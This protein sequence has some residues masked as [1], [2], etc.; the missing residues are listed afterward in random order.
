MD[1]IEVALTNDKNEG[2]LKHTKKSIQDKKKGIINE[3]FSVKERKEIL[4]KLKDYRHVDELN[5]IRVGCYARWI[6]IEN[7][8]LTTGGIIIKVDVGENG[9]YIVFKNSYKIFTVLLDNIFLFQKITNQEYI[10]L[11]II[12]KINKI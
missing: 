1:E 12:D 10:V 4:Q 11:S 5:E 7:K 2:I 6:N 9:I 3:L 8:T